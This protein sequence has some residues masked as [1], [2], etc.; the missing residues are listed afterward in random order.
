VQPRCG[1]R[2]RGGGGWRASCPARLVV[3][4]VV[5]ASRGAALLAWIR[6]CLMIERRGK[7]F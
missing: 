3:V 5:G 7:G 6:V 1:L 4:V 2:K